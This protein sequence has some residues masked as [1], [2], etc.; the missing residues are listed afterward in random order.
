MIWTSDESLDES[1]DAAAFAGDLDNPMWRELVGLSWAD[2]ERERILFQPRVEG[3]QAG[4]L[5]FVQGS[6]LLPRGLLVARW[7]RRP[8]DVVL[9]LLLP[10]GVAGVVDVETK[11]HEVSSGRHTYRMATA[12]DTISE[13]Q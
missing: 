12:G 11:T 6:L 8:S 10:P 5:D 13:E 7:E 2:G 9:E 4:F 1:L 3:G